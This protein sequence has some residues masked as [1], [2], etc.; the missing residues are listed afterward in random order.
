MLTLHADSHGNVDSIK[1]LN[2]HATSIARNDKKV[3]TEIEEA[4]QTY[5]SKLE[6]NP[7]CLSTE[8]M[9]SSLG[10][11]YAQFWRVFWDSKR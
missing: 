1:I 7:G 10:Q 3:A 11:A 2:T 6:Q 8:N 4:F 9:D 5:I